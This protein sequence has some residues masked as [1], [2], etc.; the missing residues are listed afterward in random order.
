MSWV[1]ARKQRIAKLIA[2]ALVAAGPALACESPK[3]EF[4]GLGSAGKSAAGVAGNVLTAG[5]GGEA[6]DAGASEEAMAGQANGGGSSAAMPC[7]LGQSELPCRL[8]P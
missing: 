4:G 2:G 6:A 5:S 3:R 1:C 8:A 7:T